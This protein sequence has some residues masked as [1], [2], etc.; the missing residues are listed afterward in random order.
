[1]ARRQIQEQ[2]EDA[3]FAVLME[4]AA[5]LRGQQ[6]YEEME[7]LNQSDEIE[8][9]PETDKRFRKLIVRHVR[10]FQAK[11]R[12]K[13]IRKVLNRVAIAACLAALLAGTALAVSPTLRQKLLDVLVF[14]TDQGTNFQLS[15]TGELREADSLTDSIVEEFE[16]GWVPEGFSFIEERRSILDIEYEFSTE[17]EATIVISRMSPDAM[18]ITIDTEDATVSH[19]I[20]DGKSVTISEK[21]KAIDDTV[22]VVWIDQ[23]TASF[24]M[25]TT[26]GVSK[27]DALKVVENISQ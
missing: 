15:Y 12:R 23:S 13:R 20:I 8:I 22:I 6:A 18:G 16:I 27:D 25:V 21:D 26:H 4:K 14:I 19:K 2:Y 9:P 3:L 5:Q 24:F 11:R 17:E 7:R 10:S 1:M